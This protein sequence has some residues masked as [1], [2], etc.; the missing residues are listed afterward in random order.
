MRVDQLLWLG[1]SIFV[2][3]LSPVSPMPL[4][5]MAAHIRYPLSAGT[6]HVV[7]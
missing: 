7:H 2:S 1:W 3:G 4:R 5:V 6:G